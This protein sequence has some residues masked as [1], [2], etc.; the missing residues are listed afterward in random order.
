MFVQQM[1][2]IVNPL[3]MIV[4]AFL[5]AFPPTTHKETPLVTLSAEELGTLCKNNF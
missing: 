5:V 2:G 1:I 4:I 3:C